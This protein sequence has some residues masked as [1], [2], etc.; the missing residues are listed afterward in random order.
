MPLNDLHV[1]DEVLK[2]V[3]IPSD[4]AEFVASVMVDVDKDG[5]KDLITASF[6]DYNYFFRN[7]SASG[8]RFRPG[9]LPWDWDN[10][11]NIHVQDFNG[12]GVMDLFMNSYNAWF[13]DYLM[14][15]GQRHY[16]KSF[17]TGIAPESFFIN[18]G[19]YIPYYF[20]IYGRG[21]TKGT[22]VYLKK[23]DQ[24]VFKDENP[25]YISSN[26]RYMRIQWYNNS[27]FRV[28]GRRINQNQSELLT[29]IS[30]F[31]DLEVVIPE[32]QSDGKVKEQTY[33]QRNRFYIYGNDCHRINYRVAFCPVD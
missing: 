17:L 7:M 6:F 25:K 20:N 23:D 8:F 3:K 9:I 21:F 31:Y 19:S 10:T 24:V 30:G 12:D 16:A 14:Y 4:K 13:R 15:R 22:K 5:N 33:I 27:G 18:Q 29:K 32:V 11:S 28:S 26:G 2:K 1:P